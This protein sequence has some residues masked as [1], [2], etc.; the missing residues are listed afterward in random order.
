MSFNHKYAW[1][2]KERGFTAHARAVER[3]YPGR[4]L[5]FD[6]DAMVLS[7]GRGA[8]RRELRF[9]RRIVGDVSHIDDQP[10]EDRHGR[11]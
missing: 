9:A 6:A 4:A 5:G 11:D 2:G 10:L 3:A 7:T 1:R 8:D